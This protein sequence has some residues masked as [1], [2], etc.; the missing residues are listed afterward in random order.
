MAL[1]PYE[2][3]WPSLTLKEILSL[4]F[5]RADFTNQRILLPNG[6]PLGVA[7][8]IINN[9]A[10]ASVN[11]REGASFLGFTGTQVG[12]LAINFP[13]AAADIDGLVITV[14]TQAAVGTAL[15]LASA[16]ATF[17]NAP[18]TLTAGQVIRYI[19]D[20]ATLKW[21]PA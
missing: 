15:T 10:S 8:Q 21:Y 18:A 11:L 12:T 2:T 9:N 5:L 7:K 3:P 4:G 19:Y 14:Y 16:G 6:S 17:N 13:A 1:K 20:H